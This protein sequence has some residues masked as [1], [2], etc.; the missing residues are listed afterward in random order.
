VAGGFTLDR[1]IYHAPLAG[2]HHAQPCDLGHVLADGHKLKLNKVFWDRGALV[3]RTDG[4]LPAVGSPA[5]LHLDGARRERNA[6]A[7]AAMHL[8]IAACAEAHAVFAEAPSV[9]G[10]GE[11]RVVAKFREDP[12]SALP[13]VLA[14]AQQLADAREDIVAKWSPREDV[15]KMMTQAPLPLSD[16]MPGE[17]TLRV[18]QC[19]K[20]SLVPC[21]APLVEHTWQIGKLELALVQRR[22]ESVRFG[23]KIS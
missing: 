7:H 21:D 3:H 14:R 10:G 18:V 2:Y 20:R 9:V 17:P 22:G 8:L 11:A 15:A 1:T 23:V 6:R 19:G 5:R 4:P 13:K 16:I 12:K